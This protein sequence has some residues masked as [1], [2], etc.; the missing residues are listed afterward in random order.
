[1]PRIKPGSVTCKASIL[2]TELSL[3]Y[4][5]S[6][7]CVET[8]GETFSSFEIACLLPIPSSHPCLFWGH[9]PGFILP[10][11]PRVGRAYH[12]GLPRLLYDGKEGANI[13]PY[14]Y[15]FQDLFCSFILSGHHGLS[16]HQIQKTF[17]NVQ[18]PRGDARS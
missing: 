11:P 6:H 15:S 3:L 8:E 7:L 2:L 1:M 13:V 14:P 12:Q 16:W 9:C 5:A 17:M 4:S 10:S 18:F